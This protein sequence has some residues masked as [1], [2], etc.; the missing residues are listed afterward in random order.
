MVVLYQISWNP[1][2]I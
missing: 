2:Q 1:T